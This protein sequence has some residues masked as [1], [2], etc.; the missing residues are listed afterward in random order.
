M[1]PI[2]PIESPVLLFIVWF[3]RRRGE[4]WQKVAQVG[5][6][7]EASNVSRGSGDYYIAEVRPPAPAAGLFD[8]EATVSTPAGD[9]PV[10]DTPGGC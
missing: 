8:D 9:R 10:G 1:T 2:P 7:A 5:T 4:K 3:R 6:R